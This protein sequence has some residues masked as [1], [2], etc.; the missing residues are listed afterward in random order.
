MS[1]YINIRFINKNINLKYTISVKIACLGGTKTKFLHKPNNFFLI[2]AV[3]DSK[4][5][6]KKEQSHKGGIINNGDFK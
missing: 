1:Y 5:T 3:F 2:L 6:P 4:P